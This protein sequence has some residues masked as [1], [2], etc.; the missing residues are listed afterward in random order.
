MNTR[1][2]V[3]GII[4]FAIAGFV[5]MAGNQGIQD[6]FQTKLVTFSPETYEAYKLMESIGGIVAVV[7]LLIALAGIVEKNK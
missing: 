3:S 1:W 6:I 2:F 5:F 7:G 4:I